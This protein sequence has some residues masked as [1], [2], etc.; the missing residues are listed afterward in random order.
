MAEYT[1]RNKSSSTPIVTFGKKLFERMIAARPDSVNLA[2]AKHCLSYK[3]LT[4][5]S[6]HVDHVQNEQLLKHFGANASGTWSSAYTNLLTGDAYRVVK[7]FEQ[8]VMADSISNSP[9]EEVIV[10]AELFYDMVD[11]W[12]QAKEQA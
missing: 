1:V 4:G 10:R 11:A 8:G 5:K 12:L 2:I 3:Q 9:L 6:L 7:A